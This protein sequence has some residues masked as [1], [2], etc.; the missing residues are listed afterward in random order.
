[1]CSDERWQ[2]G[3]REREYDEN[4]PNPA[5]ARNYAPQ[6]VWTSTETKHDL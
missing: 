5:R 6:H 2:T 1:L 3:N 4:L